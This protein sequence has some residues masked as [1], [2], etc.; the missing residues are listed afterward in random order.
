MEDGFWKIGGLSDR[1]SRRM[2]APLGPER[3]CW[4]LNAIPRFLQPNPT[5]WVYSVDQTWKRYRIPNM[6]EFADPRN[7]PFQ[8]ESKTG[9]GDA[10][11]LSQIQVPLVAF[12]I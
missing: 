1:P 9:M 5:L 2:R 11:K 3:K 12:R 6:V 4:F 7:D 10:A 8:T